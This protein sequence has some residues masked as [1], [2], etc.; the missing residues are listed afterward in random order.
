M[1]L[2]ISLCSFAS[3]HTM[4]FHCCTWVLLLELLCWVPFDLTVLVQLHCGFYMLYCL[5]WSAY[6]IV[7]V[8][9]AVG[10]HCIHVM[11]PCVESS[12]NTRVWPCACV[13]MLNILHVSWTRLF[14]WVWPVLPCPYSIIKCISTCTALWHVQWY[15]VHVTLSCVMNSN[16]NYDKQ[17]K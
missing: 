4:L 6:M 9:F 14:I 5:V 7:I 16:V 13:V 12:F 2:C 15:T 8:H 1:S 11:L 10:L 3:C 17:P